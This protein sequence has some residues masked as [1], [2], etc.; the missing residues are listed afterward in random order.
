MK[1]YQIF[2]CTND[3]NIIYANN[4]FLGYLRPELNRK[5]LIH[6]LLVNPEEIHNC[7]NIGQISFLHKSGHT[8]LHQT[9]IIT[10]NHTYIII[11][12][13]NTDIT[14]KTNF[15]ANMSHEIRTPLNGILGTIQLLEYTS[16]SEEQEDWVNIIKESG[17]NLLTIINDILDIT[18]L[19]ARQVDVYTR[20]FSIRKCIEES[21]D[22][23][24]VKAT[25]KKIS[26]SYYINNNVPKY[27]ISDYHRLRQILIN[28]INNAI[29]FT[30]NYGE[31]NI[32]IDAEKIGSYDQNKLPIITFNSNRYKSHNK[33][34]ATD[35]SD[36]SSNEELMEQLYENDPI[37]QHSD[38]YSIKI[39]IK[40]TGI[41]ISE[42]NISKLFRSFSQLDQSSTKQYQG[43][44]LGL[45]IC[46]QLCELLKGEIW[47]E[48]SEIGKGSTFCFTIN[49]QIFDRPDV[50]DS[51]DKLIGKKVLIVDDNHA[52]RLSLC[53]SIL[54]LGMHATNCASAQ[55]A[56]IYINNKTEFDIGLID[57]Q[58]PRTNGHQLALKIRKQLPNFPMI[59]LSSLDDFHDKQEIFFKYLVKPVKTDKLVTHMLRALS[60]GKS[61][62]TKTI[63]LSRKKPTLFGKPDNPDINI[64][65]VEDIDTNQKVI[66]GLVHKLGYTNVEIVGD[67]FT[68]YDKI[69]EKQYD[70][71]LLD[72]KMPQ[73]NGI[74]LAK[75]IREFESTNKQH[76]TIIVA[77]TAAATQ[78]EKDDYLAVNVLDDYVVKPIQLCTLNNTLYKV[79]KLEK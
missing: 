74:T 75:K 60:L 44:G 5:N 54:N 2:W 29:K 12:N 28:L 6:D 31:V 42:E 39:S 78:K 25:N 8:I 9:E 20:P 35:L 57:I 63:C 23:L 13:T 72:L 10:H 24:M 58:M 34:I 7:S 14:Y 45:A 11:A 46:K 3:W 18:K 62:S 50:D 65:V 41:G 38:I 40:D 19:E 26:I 77:V 36:S 30:N 71:I 4:N 52:N 51:K 1:D 55:E 33:T 64:L 76:P 27:I 21:I 47:V 69:K 53:N 67:G 66:L 48:H 49:T 22:I 37:Y 61:N 15:M 68:A 17:S 59:A 32:N 70:V 79:K 43:T 73:M 16:L 56:M